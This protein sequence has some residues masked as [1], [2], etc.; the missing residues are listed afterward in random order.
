MEYAK[1]EV[2][3]REYAKEEAGYRELWPRG[4]G[5]VAG[6]DLCNTGADG[7]HVI[8]RVGVLEPM[9]R[10]RVRVMVRVSLRLR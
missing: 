2:G 4:Q 7:V 9:S 1:E 6:I 5:L 3:Y 8:L 10:F